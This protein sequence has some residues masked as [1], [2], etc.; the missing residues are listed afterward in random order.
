[1]RAKATNGKD[2]LKSLPADRREAMTTLVAQVR[3]NLPKGYEESF[4]FGMFVWQVPASVYSDTYNQKPLMYAALAS[5]KSHMALYLLNVYG[6]P[7]LRRDLEAGFKAAGKRLDMGKSCLRFK[8]L[9][10]LPLDVI[11]RTIAATPMDRYVEFVKKVSA[12]KH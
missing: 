11:A 2:Y 5:Q 3:K 9:E 7:R 8:K 12:R 4:A 6:L 1:M 10:D